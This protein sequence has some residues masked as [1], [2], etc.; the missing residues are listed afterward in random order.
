MSKHAL[1]VVPFVEAR[2]IGSSQKPTAI[3]LNLSSTTSDKGAALG[4]ANYHHSVNAPLVSHHYIVDEA[5]TYRCVPDNVAA[6]QSPY[7]SLSILICAQPSESISFWESAFPRRVLYRS[8]SLVA[9]LMLTH[10]IRSRYLDEGLERKWMRHKWSSRGGLI[11]QV[12][13]KWPYE[14]FLWDVRRNLEAKGE[15]NERNTSRGLQSRS[16]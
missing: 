11:V 15:A 12:M 13:G 8:A 14:M 10:K 7:R 9:D 2:H 6:Y 4:I 1:P 16:G 3:V 5:E